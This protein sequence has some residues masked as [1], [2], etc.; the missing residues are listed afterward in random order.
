MSSAAAMN[1]ASPLRKLT[2]R[3]PIVESGPLLRLA[4][5]PR[6]LERHFACRYNVMPPDT[7]ITAPVTKLPASEAR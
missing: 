1:I 6:F 3:A 7:G 2:I 5:Q 4:Q